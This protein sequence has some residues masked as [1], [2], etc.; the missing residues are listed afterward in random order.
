MVSEE[1][2]LNQCF[3][4]LYGF[5]YGTKFK[6][7]D[8]FETILLNP[9][10]HMAD[11][12]Y[13]VGYSDHMD[14]IRLRCAVNLA[15]K[16][17]LGRDIVQDFLESVRLRG[18]IYEHNLLILATNCGMVSADDAVSSCFHRLQG[19]HLRKHGFNISSKTC[20]TKLVQ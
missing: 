17:C 4:I 7:N 13:F 18:N 3:L 20:D 11:P 8:S 15:D 12:F 10:Y 5:R 6:G 2:R 16:G 14:V 9:A 19:S 1:I